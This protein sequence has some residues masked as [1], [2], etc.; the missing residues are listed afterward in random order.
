M[1]KYCKGKTYTFQYPSPLLGSCSQDGTLFYVNPN[2]TYHVSVHD[3]KYYLMTVRELVF[4][5]ILRVYGSKQK[6]NFAV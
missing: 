5:R 1:N 4:P 2:K 6:V 3:P